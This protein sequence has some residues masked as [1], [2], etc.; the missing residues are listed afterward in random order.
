MMSL[1]LSLRQIRAVGKV[2]DYDFFYGPNR[3]KLFVRHRDALRTYALQE[4]SDEAGSLPKS[5]DAAVFETG[6]WASGDL[7][8]RP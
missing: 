1:V 2:G 4:C 8:R 3:R 5:G 7:N 6:S